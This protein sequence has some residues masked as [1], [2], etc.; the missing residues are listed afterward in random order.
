VRT[1]Q[2]G[3]GRAGSFRGAWCVWRNADPRPGC[4]AI[5]RA[6][7]NVV[8]HRRHGANFEPRAGTSAADGAVW[9][10]TRE[11]LLASFGRDA[12]GGRRAT[13]RVRR[14]GGLSGNS[15]ASSG[16]TKLSREDLPA[17]RPPPPSPPPP[18]HAGGFRDDG[19]S[20]AVRS[21]GGIRTM[22]SVAGVWSNG[23]RVFRT[24]VRGC[25]AA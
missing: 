1:R 5:C 14:G 10:A 8:T 17:H 24:T 23:G 2:G 21:A 3:V 18:V 19:H 15:Y 9:V 7:G 22:R 6:D 16:S 25:S 20:G 4:R 11:I 12:P 13:P